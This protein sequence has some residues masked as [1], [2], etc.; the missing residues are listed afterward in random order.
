M[1]QI[2]FSGYISPALSDFLTFS[3]NFKISQAPLHTIE[4]QK[5]DN[6]RICLTH[7]R[8]IIWVQLMQFYLHPSSH[9]SCNLSYS[10]KI[11]PSITKIFMLGNVYGWCSSLGVYGL[12]SYQNNIFAIVMIEPSIVRYCHHC[13]QHICWT[14]NAFFFLILDIQRSSI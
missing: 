9:P 12:H 3:K 13:H 4:C 11:G 2:E 10:L 14:Y 8:P 6:I 5:L 7:W 1:K